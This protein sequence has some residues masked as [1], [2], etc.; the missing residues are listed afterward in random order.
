VTILQNCF[1]STINSTNNNNR[2]CKINIQYTLNTSKKIDQ[3]LF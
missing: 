1:S 2:N 3:R